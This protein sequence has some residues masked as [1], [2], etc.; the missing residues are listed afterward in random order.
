MKP[1][2]Q[3]IFVAEQQGKAGGRNSIRCRLGGQLQF[4]RGALE[5]CSS[6]ALEDVD[7]DL[8]VML[9]AIAFADRRVPRRRGTQ[10]GR[11]LA[12][13][14]PVF[15]LALWEARAAE[16]ASLL[17]DVTGDSWRFE[18]RRRSHADDLR[19]LFL[20]QLPRAHAGAT[21]VPYSGGLDSFAT[22]AQ[23]RVKYGNA[24]LLLVHAQHGARAL[25]AVL[26]K[27]DHEVPALAVP[28]KVSSGMHADPSYRTRTFVFFSLAALAWRRND[29][30][31]IWIGESGIG[32]LGPS[33]VP[34][35]SEQPVCGCHPTFITKL[36]AFFERLWGERPPFELP[37][38]WLTKG[39]VV[40]DLQAHNA[41]GGWERTRSCSRNVKRQHPSAT[42]THCGVCSGCLFRRQSLRAAKLVEKKGTYYAD[43]LSDAEL[44]ADAQAAD[45]EVA[46]YAA[47]DLEELARVSVSLPRYRGHVHETATATRRPLS[48]VEAQ[49]Q[50]LFD[51]HAD[52]WKDFL[53]AV[54]KRSWLRHVASQQAGAQWMQ[55]R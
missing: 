55:R 37:N 9:A 28:F 51:R 3:M 38:L 43:V 19:Q 47:L 10:W 15:E 50:R 34:F 4:D 29:A 16:L 44:P 12:L 40:A 21:I 54:P 5:R 53:D 26:P 48:E 39:E 49:V 46:T 23:H 6:T 36:A 8:L 7:V 35:G 20:P 11:S 30:A 1:E 18:Y 32:C 45:R 27:R 42:A 41:L 17:Y 2:E 14:I 31:R 22:V 33:L 52:E 24:P 25:H 13:S